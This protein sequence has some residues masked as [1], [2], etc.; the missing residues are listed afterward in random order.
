MRRKKKS[1]RSAVAAVELAICLPLLITLVM[2]SIECCNV[3]F[4]K[5]SL[6]T[7]AYESIR[8][9]VLPGGESGE[10][11]S[12]GND[13]LDQREVKDYEV[14]FY[15]TDV[16]STSAGDEITATVRANLQSNTSL[17]G[18]I[19]ETGTLSATVTMTKT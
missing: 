13:F 1:S 6:Q 14:S 9:A 8:I 18:W 3:L 17:L 12:R 19:F 5:Q 16:S 11:I 7:A 10:A 2:G 4:L 15:P